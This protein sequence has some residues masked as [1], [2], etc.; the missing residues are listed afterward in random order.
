MSAPGQ[1]CEFCQEECLR[2]TCR[3]R[4]QYGQNAMKFRWYTR[5]TKK[6]FRLAPFEARKAGG[7]VVRGD[8]LGLLDCRSRSDA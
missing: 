2:F 6:K 4:L 3:D 8:G 5:L 1:S 7:F